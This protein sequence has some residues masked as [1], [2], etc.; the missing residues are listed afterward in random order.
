MSRLNSDLRD[1]YGED[2]IS[3]TFLP[4]HDGFRYEMSNCLFEAT[5][6][7]IL[8]VCQVREPIGVEKINEWTSPF[9]GGGV[10]ASSIHHK[11][12]QK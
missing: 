9:Q 7:Q 1:C 3:L 5:F 12:Y 11:N 8:E 2:E 6:E 10:V 4:R